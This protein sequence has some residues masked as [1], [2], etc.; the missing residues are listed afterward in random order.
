MLYRQRSELVIPGLCLLLL[1]R[2]VRS[3]FPLGTV[4]GLEGYS[5]RRTIARASPTVVRVKE[6]EAS[7]G[8]VT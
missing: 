7:I 3:F 6:L 4:G 2:G 8:Q 1:L 5:Y